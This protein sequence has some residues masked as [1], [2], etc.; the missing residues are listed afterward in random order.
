[1]IK[2]EKLNLNIKKAVRGVLSVRFNFPSK[3]RP[4]K[5]IRAKRALAKTLL[6]RVSFTVLIKSL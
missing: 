2:L 5:L 4:P 1:M 3:G 6:K